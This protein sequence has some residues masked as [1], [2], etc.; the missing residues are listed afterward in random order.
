MEVTQ[1]PGRRGSSYQARN[2]NKDKIL[3]SVFDLHLVVD[4]AGHGGSD[5]DWDGE[6]REERSDGLTGSSRAAQIEGNGTDKG[7][8][9]A[10]TDA[11]DTADREEDLVL[12]VSGMDGRG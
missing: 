11:E 10:V 12:V 9:A 7:D 3:S 2:G 6:E 4:D 5:C 8:E 1:Q